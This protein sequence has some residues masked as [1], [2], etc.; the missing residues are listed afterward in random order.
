MSFQSAN[1]PFITYLLICKKF[2]ASNIE[3]MATMAMMMMVAVGRERTEEC[4]TNT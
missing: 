1:D 4:K 3:T 2:S